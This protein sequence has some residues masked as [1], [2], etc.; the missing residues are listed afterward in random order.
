MASRRSSDCLA[1]VRGIDYSAPD[2]KLEA[3][4]SRGPG[5][6]KTIVATS[7]GCRIAFPERPRNMPSFHLKTSLR[8]FLS[9]KGTGGPKPE[10]LAANLTGD[11]QRSVLSPAKPA[12]R[13]LPKTFREL[14]LC[15]AMR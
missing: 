1:G 15:R 10:R 13:I 2:D 8:F 6:N 12:R 4:T 7:S 14:R 9:R 5:V 11:R 3:E